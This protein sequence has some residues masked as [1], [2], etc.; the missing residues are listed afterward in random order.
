MVVSFIFTFS[1]WWAKLVHPFLYLAIAILV[2]IV[3][4][5]LASYFFPEPTEESLAGLTILTPKKQPVPTAA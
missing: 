4:G 1:V 2:S 3:V 5:Y